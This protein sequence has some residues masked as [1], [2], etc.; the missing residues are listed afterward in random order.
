[1]AGLF[2]PRCVLWTCRRREVA[3]HR[4]I[5]KPRRLAV[6]ARCRDLED[7]LLT[8][9]ARVRRRFAISEQRIL[10]ARQEAAKLAVDTEDFEMG[11][12]G[13]KPSLSEYEGS[14]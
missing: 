10:R 1:M 9:E 13:R 14:E 3:K 2:R 5:A 8:F 6:Y 7:V 12:G 11:T 4:A